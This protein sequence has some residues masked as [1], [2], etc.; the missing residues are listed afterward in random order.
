MSGTA[1]RRSDRAKL[2]RKRS[3]WHW[4]RRLTDAAEQGKVIDTPTPCSCWMCGNP[5]RYFGERRIGERRW[6]Q[7]AGEN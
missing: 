2:K 7:D 5:R 6:L 3:Y 4:G 1:N